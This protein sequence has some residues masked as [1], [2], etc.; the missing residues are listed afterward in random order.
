[1]AVFTDSLVYRRAVTAKKSSQTGRYA[2]T[3]I[4]IY[5]MLRLSGAV[6][7]DTNIKSLAIVSFAVFHSGI[8]FESGISEN[9][10]SYT[11]ISKEK[12]YSERS[13]VII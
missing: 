3:Y 11:L 4:Y 12:Q 10:Q 2:R 7:T 6:T 5:N 8:K 1:M 13:S 9:K